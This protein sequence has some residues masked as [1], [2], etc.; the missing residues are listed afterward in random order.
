[1]LFRMYPSLNSAEISSSGDPVYLQHLGDGKL[2]HGSLKEGQDQKIHHSVD[3]LIVTLK[4]GGCIRGFRAYSK[5]VGEGG[6][7][8]LLFPSFH[9]PTIQSGYLGWALS[10]RLQCLS[11]AKFN[12][13][14]SVSEGKIWPCVSW[15]GR[16]KVIPY[17]LQRL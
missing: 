11:Q 10:R 6:L 7:I 5:F 1:M 17:L 12:T 14:S 16:R 13:I 9:L 4:C 3:S 8:L 2:W 15:C